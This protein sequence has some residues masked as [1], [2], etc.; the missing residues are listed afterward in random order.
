MGPKRGLVPAKRLRPWVLQGGQ[1]SIEDAAAL[2]ATCRSDLAEG[3][4]RLKHQARLRSA[5]YD[6]GQ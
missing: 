2:L 4:T 6:H 1:W 5:G 3:L